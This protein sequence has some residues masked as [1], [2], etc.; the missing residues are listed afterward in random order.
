[1]DEL[2]EGMINAVVQGHRHTQSHYFY[3]GVPIIGTT[4]GGYYLNTVKLR[5]TLNHTTAFLKAE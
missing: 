4:N 2:P 1:L 5:F 3:K